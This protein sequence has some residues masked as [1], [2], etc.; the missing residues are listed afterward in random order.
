MRAGQRRR[1]GIP[2]FLA[3]P[4]FYFSPDILGY[5]FGPS[6]PL[7]PERLRRTIDLLEAMGHGGY[8]ESP[9]AAAEDVERVHAPE[10]RAA[11]A[12]ISRA[13]DEGKLPE[14]ADLRRIH[15]FYGDNPPFPGIYEAALAYTGATVEAAR[16]VRDGAPLA[17][18]IGG[19]L[20]HAQRELASGFC[21]FN[22]PAIAC[23]ILRERFDRVAYVD[24]DVHHGDGVQWLFYDDPTVLTCSIHEDGRTLYPGSG[25]VAE[26]GAAFTSVNVPMAAKTT[27]DVWL[28]AFERAILPALERFRP[29]ALVLQLGT[30]AHVDDP[31][32]HL[33]CVQ[34]EWLAAVRH[35]KDL[36]LPTVAL[37]GGGYNLDTVPRMWVSA[38]LTLS[39]IAF[40]DP[41]PEPL[42]NAWGVAA[43]G[44]ERLPAPRESGN[45]LAAAVIASLQASV[46]PNVPAG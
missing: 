45:D 32:G 31:L 24:I 21:V 25:F 27:G 36:G 18:G 3:L 11:V 38:C 37:G 22:D 6:H 15:G 20:H 42:A 12:A 4:H 7:K 46:L 26:T 8:L 5:D 33:R 10:Y 1:S 9:P 44:D 28:W 19:G 43:F 34:Q 13:A 39:G 16:A 17:F 23:H 41:L 30:D 40:E 35:L 29:Q 2:K 14:V